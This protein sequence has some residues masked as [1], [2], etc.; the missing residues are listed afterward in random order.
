[1]LRVYY[2]DDESDLCDL[3]AELF[4]AGD[5][6]VRT[7]TSPLEALQVMSQDPPDFLFSDYRM[8]EMN[9]IELAKRA[10]EKVRKFLIT[11]ESNITSDFKFEAIIRKPLNSK[12][13]KEIFSSANS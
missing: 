9:G 11:G 12:Q 5:V 13:L 6:E 7:F 1:M 4:T 10:P 8:P 2:V 3:F